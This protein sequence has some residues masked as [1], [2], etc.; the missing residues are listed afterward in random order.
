[1]LIKHQQTDNRGRFYLEL[2]DEVLAELLVNESPERMIIEHTEVDD[3]LRGRNVGL[4]LV[5][6]AVEY[7]RQKNLKIQP[8]C[9]FAAKVFEKKPEL[10][11]V[12]E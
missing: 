12:L 8:L 11:D 10:R 3:E 7:A 4:E 1:M 6:A 2:N 9:P 5:Q